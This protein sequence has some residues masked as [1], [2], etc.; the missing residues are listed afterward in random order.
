MVCIER[1]TGE[2]WFQVHLV[3]FEKNGW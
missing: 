3:A 1:L 2:N